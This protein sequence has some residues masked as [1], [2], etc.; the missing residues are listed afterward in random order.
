MALFIERAIAVSPDLAVDDLVAA[1]IAAV[2]IALDGLP[3]AIELAAARSDVLSPAAIR[4][5]LQ[6]RFALLIG[7]AADAAERQ[8]TLRAAIDWSFELLSPAQRTFFARLGAFAG[9][10]D[11]DAS[12]TVAGD[13]LEAPLELL[14]SLVKQS[15]VAR[16]GPDRYRLLDTLR[17]YALE[18]LADLDA[19]DDPRP[20]RRCVRAAGRAG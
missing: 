10:F 5:R 17:A 12:L 11:L 8:Q 1:D 3:L 4:T 18:V 9:T 7:G 13:G 6:D 20:P 19:D 14:S 2:C 15:M 16:A